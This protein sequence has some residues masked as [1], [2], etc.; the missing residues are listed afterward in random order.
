M[1]SY[2]Q[3]NY[4]ALFGDRQ[5]VKQL[6]TLAQSAVANKTAQDVNF[7]T[8]TQNDISQ[9]SQ[10]TGFMP[11]AYLAD[12]QQDKIPQ[13]TQIHGGLLIALFHF[14]SHRHVLLDLACQ[15]INI[16]APIA[17]QSYDELHQLMQASSAGVA[18]KLQL[19][20]VEG[21]GVGKA[22]LRGLK[23]GRVG[24]IYVDG[25]MGPSTSDSKEGTVDVEFFQYDITVKAGIARLALLLNLPILPVFCND[26]GKPSVD[27]GE[28]I[29]PE[30]MAA[31]LSRNEKTQI[32]LQQLYSELQQRVE[33]SPADWEYALCFHR[34]IAKSKKQPKSVTASLV[35]I[36]TMDGM[37]QLQINTTE[38]S[39]IDKQESLYWV[40]TL[41][42]K[43]FKVPEK[44]I[45]LFREMHH[46]G[47][48]QWS[49]FKQEVIKVAAQPHNLLQQMLKNQLVYLVRFNHDDI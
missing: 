24:G 17:G 29:V 41:L 37:T 47:H 4:Q 25:N 39:V 1:L 31:E 28:I 22:L 13:L 7:C 12:W 40:N 19:L 43:G 30:Q 15:N 44:L 20:E 49:K 23:N 42:A 16:V 14:G 48:I 34:W 32:I 18:D 5:T 46:E 26:E 33:R 27:Y 3:M 38:L 6:Q 11:N 9:L 35:L 45:P 10:Q 36:D 21:N 2:Y 8:R